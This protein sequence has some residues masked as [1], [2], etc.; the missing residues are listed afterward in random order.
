MFHLSDYAVT[1]RELAILES[2]AL[3]DRHGQITF[4]G[5]VREADRMA[6]FNA[7]DIYLQ[8]E[9]GQSYGVQRVRVGKT[10]AVSAATWRKWL[11]G[12]DKRAK[13]DRVTLYA[14]DRAVRVEAVFPGEDVGFEVLGWRLTNVVF[15]VPSKSTIKIPA[16]KEARIRFIAD[17]ATNAAQHIPATLAKTSNAKKQNQTH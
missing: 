9:C 12:Y 7:C 1:A 4:D 16:A 17:E 15:W 11:A 8:W 14:A 6:C 10:K 5:E 2:G 3:I 13:C